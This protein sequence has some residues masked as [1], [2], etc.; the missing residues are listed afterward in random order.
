MSLKT[1][2]RQVC[3]PY[4]LHLGKS[5]SS[6]TTLLFGEIINMHTSVRTVYMMVAMEANFLLFYA[7]LIGGLNEQ[8]YKYLIFKINF[9]E[10]LKVMEDVLQKF[11]VIMQCLQ[12]GGTKMLEICRTAIYF[13]NCKK[14]VVHILFFGGG[15]TLVF[16]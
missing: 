14:K 3:F 16:M 8:K 6:Q 1:F 9:L 13:E 15:D 5:W 2:S 10:D 12:S 11:T 4:R 7:G